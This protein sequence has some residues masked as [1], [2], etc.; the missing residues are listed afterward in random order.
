MKWKENC[1]NVSA[2]ANIKNGT[3][4]V[5]WNRN[6]KSTYV[7]K[8]VLPKSEEDQGCLLKNKTCKGSVADNPKSCLRSQVTSSFDW[9][10]NYFI[11]GFP[12]SEKKKTS[13]SLVESSIED[14]PKKPS[15]YN[16]IL[17]AA[18]D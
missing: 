3:T 14:D 15:I 11:C 12:C 10:K 7:M 8:K 9:K 17:G 4:K 2:E 16:K 6:C 1:Y 18:E 13:S 5:S